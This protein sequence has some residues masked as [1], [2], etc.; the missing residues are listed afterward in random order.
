MFSLPTTTSLPMQISSSAAKKLLYLTLTT[1][2]TQ[3]APFGLY[4]PRDPTSHNP[5]VVTTSTSNW[6]LLWLK[7][8][9]TLSFI[10][11]Q[12]FETLSPT[13]E[14][15]CLPSQSLKTWRFIENDPIKPRSTNLRRVRKLAHHA[16]PFL[17]P[18]RLPRKVTSTAAYAAVPIR[19]CSALASVTTDIITANASTNPTTVAAIAPRDI[20][21]RNRRS[22]G[23]SRRATARHT[24]IVLTTISIRLSLKWS[25]FSVLFFSSRSVCKKRLK[26]DGLSYDVDT[27]VDV[28]YVDVDLDYDGWKWYIDS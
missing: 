6:D 1:S 8:S 5:K 14:H 20:E 23:V 11:A 12:I 19:I 28:V 7:A 18:P 27:D 26:G 22:T 2:L 13:A 10:G 3:V 4:E 24:A 25:I 9:V 17:I 15:C 21:T 16:L